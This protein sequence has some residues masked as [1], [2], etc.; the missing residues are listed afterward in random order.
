MEPVSV[1]SLKVLRSLKVG[2]EVSSRDSSPFTDFIR[3]SNAE[4][5]SWW[6]VG[7][8][9]VVAELVMLRRVGAVTCIMLGM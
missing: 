9:W 8:G 1:R 5:A 3:D 4:S 2:G 7:E 6:V